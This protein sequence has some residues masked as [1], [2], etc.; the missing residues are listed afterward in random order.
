MYKPIAMKNQK[1]SIV[2]YLFMCVFLLF[3]SFLFTSCQK[4]ESEF[5]NDTPDETLTASSVLAKL[6]LNTSQNSG[7]FDDF[8]DGT[9]CSSIQ[10]PYQV[11]V[12]GQTITLENEEDVTA[13]S[14]TS[15]EITIVFPITVVFEDFSTAVVNDQQELNAL[16]EVCDSI[17]EAINC[18]SLVYPVTFFTYNADNEQTGTVVIDSDANL[19]VFLTSLDEDTYVALDFPI[20][21]VLADGSNVTVTSNAQ[22]QGL[23]ESCEDIVTDPP[24]PLELENLLTTDSWFVS[25]FFDD[26]DETYEFAGFEFE[27]NTDGTATASNGVINEPGTWAISTSSSGSLKL[28]LDFG[29]EDPVDELDEDWKV[30]DFSNDLIRLKDG[31]EL[32]SFSRTPNTGGISGEALLLSDT[33]IDG[34]WF[35][36]LYLEDGDED[37]TSNYNSFSFDFLENGTVVASN[38]TG[39]FNGTWFIT[40][41]DGN[42]KVILNFF[43]VYP[44]DELDEDWHVLEFQNNQVTLVED[45]DDNADVLVFEKL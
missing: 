8:I 17:D 1:F 13:L 36:A 27:F 11:I 40:G 22:L 9:S 28:I 15:A 25:F 37:E 10:F 35:V 4:E 23:I 41:S 3:M 6:L 2:L 39:N 24:S 29:D 42:L 33:M 12:N 32:L 26:E 30:I 34:N 7:S 21:V 19:F 20:T 44:L 14:N 31:D 45:D 16:G 18:I 38:S 5:I 43:D